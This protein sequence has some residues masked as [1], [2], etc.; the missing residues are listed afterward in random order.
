MFIIASKPGQ[1]GNRL[2]IFAQFVGCAIENGIE[3]MNPAFD[4]YASYFQGTRHD[5]L[6]RFP[7]RSSRLPRGRLT[8]RLLYQAS[9][10]LARVLVRARI[11]S[12]RL[13]AISLEWEEAVDMSEPAFLETARRRLLF[14]Q[15]WQFRDMRSLKKHA[16]A[17]RD[18]FR[19][20]REVGENVA[21]LVAAA[22]ARGDVLV[23]L[24]IRRG[25]Y[26]TFMGGRFF[27]EPDAYASV[28]EKVEALFPGRRVSFLICSNE[29]PD[30]ETFSRFDYTPGSNHFVE[31]MYALAECDYI[32]GPPSTYTMWASFYGATPLY[33]IADPDRTP[34]LEEFVIHGIDNVA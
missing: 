24:H 20:V 19:P 15:G 29:P 9:Y 8:R 12:G 25:D 32:V 5:L 26:R 22:R 11:E 3:L 16:A 1:L 4:E 33:M 6:C 23:G 21:R 34:T 27:Y 14:L 31:D 13:K 7:P 2:Y 18:F 28:L 10:Y 30:A 17:I